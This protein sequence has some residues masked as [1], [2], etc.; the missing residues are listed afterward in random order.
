MST[1][2]RVIVVMGHPARKYVDIVRKLFDR[3][4]EV[5]VS[6]RGRHF[7]RLAEVM[8]LLRPYVE[9]KEAQFSYADRAPE[10]GIV[11]VPASSGGGRG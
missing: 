1:G 6:A 3:Y 5:V 2:N 8:K 10:L 4:D 11:V 9:V 7:S